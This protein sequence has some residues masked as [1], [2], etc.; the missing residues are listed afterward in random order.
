M[1]AD[2]KGVT[3][4]V[5]VVAA[6]T[7]VTAAAVVAAA[8]PVTGMT[9][10]EAITRPGSARPTARV[11]DAAPSWAAGPA[12]KRGTVMA[13]QVTRGAAGKIIVLFLPVLLV[14][15]V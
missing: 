6:A 15:V 7:A 2:E 12:T 11:V 5:G 13:V 14:S 8:A 4:V 10:G 9:L 3:D 1:T